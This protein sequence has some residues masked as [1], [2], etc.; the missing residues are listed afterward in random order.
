QDGDMQGVHEVLVVLQPVAG[1]DH[2][3]ATADAV[4][5]GLEELAGIEDLERLPAGQG[6][7][8]IRRAEV[9][10]DQS[11]ALLHRIPGLPHPVALATATGLAR[12]LQAVP[13]GVEE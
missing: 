4:R 2:G 13:L 12:L 9:R 11:V 10:E 8:A 7:L 3:P 6:G 5:I 1:D